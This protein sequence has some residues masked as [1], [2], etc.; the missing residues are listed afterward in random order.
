MENNTPARSCP[1]LARLDAVIWDSET[2]I[3]EFNALLDA[4]ELQ[5]AIEVELSDAAE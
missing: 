3:A 5:F 4:I 2:W 1:I